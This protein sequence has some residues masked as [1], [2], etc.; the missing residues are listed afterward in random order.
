MNKDEG[1]VFTTKSD[2]GVGHLSVWISGP[3]EV[4]FSTDEDD[5]TLTRQQLTE[6]AAWL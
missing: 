4:S 6:L 2:N 3:D 1:L 5:F